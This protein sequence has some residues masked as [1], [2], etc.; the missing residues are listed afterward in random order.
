MLEWAIK[1]TCT[2]FFLREEEREGEGR[3]RER[4][5]KRR[6]DR[7]VDRERRERRGD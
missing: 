7:G 2:Y 3:Q 1:V 5:R 6:V 4:R